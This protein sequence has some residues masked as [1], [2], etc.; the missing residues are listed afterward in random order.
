[1]GRSGKTAA[2]VFQERARELL[3]C[4]YQAVPR[5]IRMLVYSPSSQLHYRK[6]RARTNFF[7]RLHV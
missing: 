6:N 3:G 2:K 5:L 4:Y 1:M 7:Y